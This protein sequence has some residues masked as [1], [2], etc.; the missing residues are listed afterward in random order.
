M[1][2][3]MQNLVIKLISKILQTWNNPEVS[4]SHGEFS[5]FRLPDRHSLIFVDDIIAN[6][7][8]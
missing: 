3:T 4:L 8:Q 6:L 1:L 2:K 7:V 5:I